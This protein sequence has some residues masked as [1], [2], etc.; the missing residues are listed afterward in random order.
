M[1]IGQRQVQIQQNPWIQ[2]DLLRSTVVT[3][4]I[5]QG[6]AH[7][8]EEWVTNLQIQYGDSVDTL[9]YILENGQPQGRY[10]YIVLIGCCT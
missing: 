3:G 10:F 9:R 8:P 1:T 2:V 6:S 7:A 5:T 4:I